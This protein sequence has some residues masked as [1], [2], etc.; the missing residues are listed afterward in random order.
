MESQTV[1][2]I[3]FIIALVVVIV[4]LVI[5][6]CQED[7]SSRRDMNSDAEYRAQF[8]R[9]EHLLAQNCN[10]SLAEARFLMPHLK[11]HM[12]E[13]LKSRNDFE[14]IF[15]KVKS[16]KKDSAKQDLFQRMLRQ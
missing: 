12:V 13:K 9:K 10:V 16:D 11:S 1:G 8:K 15:Q 4:A 2:V 14:L 7:G 5:T 6:C 3:F